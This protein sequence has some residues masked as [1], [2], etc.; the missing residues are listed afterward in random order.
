MIK[1]KKIIELLKEKNREGLRMLYN[2]KYKKIYKIAYGYTGIK[3]D[4]EDILQETFIRVFNKID[5]FEY[6]GENSL[7][8]WVV[9]ICINL[10]LDYLRKKKREKIFLFKKFTGKDKENISPDKKMESDNS[11]KNIEKALLKLSAKQRIVFSLKYI[12]ELSVKDIAEIL[13]C[14]PNTVKKHI[15]R[16]LIKIRRYYGGKR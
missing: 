14:S 7:D 3:E 2:M 12:D 15:Y 1:E 9:R 6:D 8:K 13:N 5:R 4:A 10:S 16:G 11:I